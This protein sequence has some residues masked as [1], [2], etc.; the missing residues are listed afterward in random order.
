[1]KRHSRKGSALVSVIWLLAVLSI[2]IA[3][4]AVDAHLQTRINIYLRERVAVDH[5]TDAGLA[6]AEVILTDYQNVSE[7]SSDADLEKLQED[8]R[9]YNEKRLLKSQGGKEVSTG[10]VP[11]DA[12]NP[13]GGTVT[14]TIRPIESKFNINNLYAGGDANFAEIWMNILAI[15]GVPK[16]YWDGIVDGWCDWRDPDG[17]QTGDDGAES[18]F[19]SEAYQDF[20]DG[21]DEEK[22]KNYKP[23]ARDGEIVDLE[24]LKSIKGFNEYKEQPINADAI[25]N[26]GVLNPDE[27]PENQIVITNGISRFF[28]VYGSGKINVNAVKDP[29]V[30]AAIPGIYAGNPD[31]PRAEDAS[32]AIAI[33][34]K[35][36]ERR[37]MEPTDGR[38]P[39]LTLDDDANETGAYKDMNSLQERLQELEHLDVQNEAS[40]YF[41]FQPEKFF[42]ITIVG[43]SFGIVHKIVAIALVNEDGKVRYLRWQE[44]P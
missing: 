27:D 35:I 29:L 30:L 1:M 21:R 24:E 5:L 22:N 32:A 41:A 15:S 4:Y 13:E 8:D 37:E 38:N 3:S 28:S 40:T 10:A 7:A 42:E 33:A 39:L 23:K 9:W 43:K 17:T 36:I 6:I 19:Y 34:E 12:L 14:V 20:V 16:D 2:L 44:D 18:D 11:V 25:L 31:D 26:G